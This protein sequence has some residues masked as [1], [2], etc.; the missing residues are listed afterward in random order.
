M[1]LEELMV[2]EEIKELL[3]LEKGKTL[4]MAKEAYIKYVLGSCVGNKTNTA[5]IL[6]IDR[7][8]VY[9]SYS[10]LLNEPLESGIDITKVTETPFLTLKEFEILHMI[11]TLE[12]CKWNKSKAKKTLGV[13]RKTVYRVFKKYGLGEILKHTKGPLSLSRETK[14][15]MNRLKLHER[16][17]FD[18]GYLAGYSPGD[19]FPVI[20]IIKNARL[21]VD[22][23]KHPWARFMRYCIDNVVNSK[24]DVLVECAWKERRYF[25][26]KAGSETHALTKENM[27]INGYFGAIE[28]LQLFVGE[29]ERAI[30][31]VKNKGVPENK[32]P[33]DRLIEKKDHYSNKLRQIMETKL[34]PRLETAPTETTHTTP[35]RPESRART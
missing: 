19:G 13:D 20:K 7:K 30:N 18:E 8:T 6:G 12:D 11:A 15:S 16:Y 1:N 17:R 29:L 21:V 26:R 33:V 4:E 24:P 2:P 9:R 27:A 35:R 23:P 10:H 5:R 34:K 28:R 32:W 22:D 14:Q 3:A 25:N 31:C